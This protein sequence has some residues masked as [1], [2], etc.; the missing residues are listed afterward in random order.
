L[1]AETPRQIA[2]AHTAFNVINTLLFIWFTSAFGR[3]VQRLIPEKPEDVPQV[4]K[5]KYLGD[6]YLQTPSLALDCVRMELGHMGQYVVGMLQQAPDAIV[7]GTRT[8]LKCLTDSDDNVDALSEAIVDYIRRL[9]MAGLSESEVRRGQ[10]YLSIADKLESMGDL[11]EMNLA[12]QGLHRI[13]HELKFSEQTVQALTPLYDAVMQALRDALKALA[14]EDRQLARKVIARKP[15]IQELADHASAHLA[16]RLTT[17][18]P[19][20]VAVFRVESDII[21]Q[22]KR[23]YYYA[24]RIAKTI[25]RIDGEPEETPDE[26]R[27]EVR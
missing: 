20:R 13:E 22:I 14:Q 23:L 7:Q 17:D 2:N 10:D 26:Q 27:N 25:A 16:R 24:K 12:A 11:I 8:D 5:P 21:S 1:A 4:A 6:E 19:N 3:L 18:E 9:A 15:E